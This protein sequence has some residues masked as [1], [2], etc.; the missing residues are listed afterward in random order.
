[1]TDAGVPTADLIAWFRME[2]GAG[3]TLADA[4]GGTS[5]RVVQPASWVPARPG[6]GDLHA[7]RFGRGYASTSP[8]NAGPALAALSTQFSVAA[9]LW[10]DEA[11]DFGDQAIAGT[12]DWNLRLG[13]K[14]FP[15]LCM[16]LNTA[17]GGFN[18]CGQAVARGG[19]THV[20]ATWDGTDLRL[21]LNGVQSGPSKR[22]TGRLLTWPPMAF[23]VG[24]WGGGGDPLAGA[25][26]DVRV[27]ARALTAAE[28]AALAK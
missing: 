16:A 17:N 15:H 9:W 22:V 3:T 6:S 28:V 14:G 13:A 25:L 24:C 1:M 19:W 2:E 23:G 5:L 12:G 8:N 10:W 18:H 4:R 7:V 21:F 26:D 27:Y 11:N 20:A